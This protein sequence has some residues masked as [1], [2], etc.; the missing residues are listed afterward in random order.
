MESVGDRLW[1]NRAAGVITLENTKSEGENLNKLF[2]LS[3]TML[4]LIPSSAFPDIFGIGA[5]QFTIDFVTI[6][7]DTNPTAGYGTVTSDYRI[8][9]YEVTNDQWNKF[10]AVHG[11]VNGTPSNAYDSSSSWTGTDI[12]VQNVSWY[13]AAQFVN[14]L[15][16]STGHTAAYNFTG[17]PGQS[18]YAFAVWDTADAGYNAINPFRNRN[19][20]YFLPT[21]DEWVKAAYW[22]GVALQTYATKDN[23]MPIPGVET[24]YDIYDGPFLDLW[25]V[26]SGCEELNGTYDM[27]GNVREWMESPAVAGNYLSSAT[28]TIRGGSLLCVV[29]AI[30]STHRSFAGPQSEASNDG[31]RV[32]SIP[33][34]ATSSILA[35]GTLL[36]VRRKVAGLRS[37]K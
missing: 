23:S 31:F 14:W 18:D 24:K 28:R 2:T 36:A 16:T 12:P 26:G 35:L 29:G 32:A 11:A 21:E 10:V 27:M 30:T 4:V 9:T 34:P 6:S 7:A 13:E 15:N 5:N 37:L 3:L 19:A 17:T 25:D 33:E 20:F 1:N 22:N 8:G